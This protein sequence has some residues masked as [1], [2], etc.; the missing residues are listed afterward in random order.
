MALAIVPD[1]MAHCF[2]PYYPAVS[3]EDRFYYEGMPNYQIHT[4]KEYVHGPHGNIIQYTNLGDMAVSGDQIIATITY[5]TDSA[6]N[7]LGL[8]DTLVVTDGT[9]ELRKRYATYDQNTGK[10]TRIE[11]VNGS[12]ISQIDI[13]YYGN[14]NLASLLMPADYNS[15]S[16]QLYYEY[17]AATSTYPTQ[18]PTSRAT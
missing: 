5:Y 3:A 4:R 18:P 11:Q 17:D 15:Y 2:G 16:K 1:S 10:L 14:G 7:I 13:T 9:N 8:P 6:K 12:S